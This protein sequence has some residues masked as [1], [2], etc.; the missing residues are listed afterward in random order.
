M[1]SHPERSEGS[2]IT[3]SALRHVRGA[4][5]LEGAAVLEDRLAERIAREG[6]GAGRVGERAG[7]GMLQ[8]EAVLLHEALLLGVALLRE[9]ARVALDR[10]MVG[11]GGVEARLGRRDVLIELF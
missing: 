1:Q 5:G 7:G 3:V 2:R 4:A 8:E 10:A 9:I 11:E 6:L